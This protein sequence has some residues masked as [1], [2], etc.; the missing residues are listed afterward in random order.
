M[1]INNVSRFFGHFWPT[2]LPTLSY[3]ITSNLG[4]Y[5]GPPTSDRPNIRFG[6]TSTVLFSPNDNLFLQNTVL[7]FFTI[8]CIFQ[9]GSW[10]AL[11]CLFF[12]VKRQNTISVSFSISWEED[13]F[14]W[15]IPGH[16]GVTSTSPKL[17]IV[18]WYNYL[19]ILYNPP[20][21]K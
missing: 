15:S 7:S 11:S 10:P 1:S 6:R 16:A 17:V 9:N 4:G 18:R 8:H 14:F 12:Y 2:Y 3:S 20:L 13:S 21:G 5:L 19:I